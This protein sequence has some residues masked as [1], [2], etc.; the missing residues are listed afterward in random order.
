MEAIAT[1]AIAASGSSVVNFWSQRPGLDRNL[2]KKFLSCLP[3]NFNI[4]NEIPQ[5]IGMQPSLIRALT[6]MGWAPV[7]IPITV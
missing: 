3:T 7:K 4:S 2:Q 1:S 5:M 6:H